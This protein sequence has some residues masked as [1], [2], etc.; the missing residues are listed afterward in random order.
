MNLSVDNIRCYENTGLEKQSQNKAKTK[1]KQSQN[2]AK[3]NPIKP[4]F[5]VTQYEMRDTS[6]HM[7]VSQITN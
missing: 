4:N 1:P 7:R 3:T 2:K 6:F 5:K